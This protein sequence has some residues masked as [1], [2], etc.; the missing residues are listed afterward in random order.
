M[1]NL[2]TGQFPQTRL[3]RNRQQGWSRSL[4]AE[5]ALKAEDL[6]W[7]V[8]IRED[9]VEADFK[10][11]SGVKRYLIPELLQEIAE[12]SPLGVKTVMLFPV[13]A[14]GKRDEKASE[15]F[16]EEGLL[17]QTVRAIKDRFPD[18]G[19]ITDVAL[20]PYTSHGQ[21]GLVIEGEIDNDETLKALER[22]AIVQAKAGT[23]V[24]APSEMM[25]GRVG[26][27]RRALDAQGFSNVSIMSYGAKYASCLYGPFR[28]ALGSKG[29][30]GVADKRTYQMDPANL[31]EAIREVAMDIQEGAD[32]VIVKP[33]MLYLD[34]VRHV[35]DVFKIPTFSFQVSAEYAMLKLADEAGFLTF[36]EAIIESLL[37]F[38]RA[39]ADG[40]ITYAAPHV[41]QM[42]AKQKTQSRSDKSA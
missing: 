38:K 34:V 10:S 13:V 15:A 1:H 8:F 25:D 17:C 31:D 20:D 42:L 40:I 7:P 23:D 9:S 35:K 28:E 30:L 12:I 26:V 21:D 29:C 4:M 24:I 22:H 16:N 18:V 39:G 5:N 41:A 3:R 19:V 6:I 2:I 37:C 33:G 32:S 27:I 36:D 11:L 14:Q